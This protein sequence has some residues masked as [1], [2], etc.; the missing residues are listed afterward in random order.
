MRKRVFQSGREI[1]LAGN[2]GMTWVFNDGENKYPWTWKTVLDAGQ[3]F[4]RGSG[5]NQDDFSLRLPGFR[6][7][8]RFLIQLRMV[9][10]I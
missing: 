10:S 1:Y 7:G 4:I 2:A 9:F 8:Q 5:Q 3:E 6:L